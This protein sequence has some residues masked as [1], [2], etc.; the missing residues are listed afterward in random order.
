MKKIY[1]NWNQVEG[2]CL[3]IARQLNADNWRPDYIVGITRGGLV[4][5]TLLSQYLGVKM[6]TLNVSLRD[7]ATE[8]ESNLW[9]AEDAFGYVNKEDR[10]IVTIEG[11]GIPMES[12]PSDPKVRKKILIV[13]DINDTGATL[14]WIKEDWRSGCLPD[15]Y[16]WNNIWHENVRFAVLA[17]N[18]ASKEDS[19][20]S[21]WEVN[22]AEKLCWLVFP[23][24]EYWLK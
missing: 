23:W 4:P 12:D 21:V 18:L 9:M 5:A 15:S 1:Y 24:E 13:D 6:H 17:D 22:K 3:D 19:D 10:E 8:C 20:Y 14:R 7:S 2:A 16:H 11:S